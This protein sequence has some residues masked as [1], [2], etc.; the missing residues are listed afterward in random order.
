MNHSRYALGAPALA[1]AD[2]PDAPDVAKLYRTHA[3]TVARWAWQL[4][5]PGIGVEDVVQ[6]VFLVAHRRLGD[7]HGPGKVTTWLYRT[8]DHIVRRERRRRG[9]R[10]RLH[11]RVSTEPEE[12]D[13][14]PDEVARNEAR[15]IVYT[16]LDGM[17]EKYRSAFILFELEHRSGEEIAELLSTRTETVWVWLHRARAQFL[18]KLQAFRND[19]APAVFHFPRAQAGHREDK[20]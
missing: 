1:P 14:Q 12:H 5:G 10:L 13:F 20:V 9:L 2:E 6:E 4:G 15:R 16:I 11:L 18:E 8:T 19:A 3:Q 17:K 7:F